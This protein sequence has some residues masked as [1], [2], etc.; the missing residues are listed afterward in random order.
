MERQ[1]GRVRGGQICVLGMGK[2][3]GHEMT[4]SSDLDLITIY[5]FDE[6]NGHSDGPHPMAA[7]QY[8]ARFT[9]RLISALSAPTA[10][11]QLYAVDMRLR[12]SGKAGP[13]AT[14]LSAFVRY[15]S[16][17]AWTWEHMALT[18]AR[19]VAG[20]PALTAAIEATIAEVLRQPS[21]RGKIAADVRDMRARIEVEKGTQDIWDI[22]HHR[23]GLVDVEFIAQ[24]LQLIHAHDHPQILD[25]NTITA[26][27]KLQIRGLLAAAD[28]A[29]LLP[30]AQL[31]NDLTQILR[32]CVEGPFHPDTAPDGLKSMLAAAAGV[33]DFPAVEDLLRQ[34]LAEVT[35]RF[36]ALI[37]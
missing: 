6:A 1:H 28:A 14:S 5:D 23:G 35:D 29:I 7:A 20:P 30:A 8:Y 16:S 27:E 24:Y 9:Q 32:L 22:K 21:D 2:L 18:R 37:V 19:V 31:Y 17:E 26:L 3:G 13:V 11:G 33:S 10:E 34:R 12:P 4:A 15:Q 36:D 25:T